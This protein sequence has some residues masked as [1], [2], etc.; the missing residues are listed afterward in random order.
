MAA[1]QIGIL[2]PGDMGISLAA[3][4]QRSGHV[5]AWASEGRSDATRAR[6]ERFGLLD[7]GTVA[8]LC[9]ASDVLVSICPPH[10][11][12]EQASLVAASGFGGLY[13]DAN[14]I[15][16]ARAAQICQ[17]LAGAGIDMVDG[18]IVGG[19]AWE[20]GRTWLY[21]SGP[22]ADEIAACFAA[23]PLETRVLGPSVGDASALKMCYAAYTKGT[24]ALLCGVIAAA[25][26]L[27]VRAALEQQWDQDRAGSAAQNLG[28]AR[29]VTAKA[30]RFV[31]EMEEIASTFRAAGLPGE[32]HD[33]A[34]TL[35]GRLAGFKGGETPSLDAVLEA[36]LEPEGT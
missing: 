33:A 22:R 8:A 11:A 29:Q 2:H 3:T 15:A 28:R 25:E 21:L 35:Y 27:G 18:G 30:W 19:P 31:G 5:V 13:L 17:L 24:T 10:A 1:Q 36:L 32:F 14:A 9:A 6:A 34:A 23:G 12:E 4:A 7:R 26:Q 20:P 16:P